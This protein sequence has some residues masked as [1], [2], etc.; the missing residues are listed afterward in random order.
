MAHQARPIKA[1]QKQEDTK[2]D[3]QLPR[4]LLYNAL[5]ISD[6]QEWLLWVGSV[7]PS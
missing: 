3:L 6:S 4:G 2:E 5:Y 1:L 7:T